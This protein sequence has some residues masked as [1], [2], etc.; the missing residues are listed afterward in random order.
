MI[1]KLAIIGC[2]VLLMSSCASRKAY[3]PDA[4][5]ANTNAY[6]SFIKVKRYSTYTNV[7]G[8][9]IA[10]DS[11][12]II[13]MDE[14][15]DQCVRIPIEDIFEFK[16]RY[17]NSRQYGW[18]IPFAGILPF[19]HGFYSLLTIPTHLIVTII[20]TSSGNR[21]YTYNSRVISY[22]ELVM[23]ARFPQGLPPNVDLSLIK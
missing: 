23:F 5:T 8:E 22:K 4:E 13:V 17:A 6:G 20:V 1:N 12:S 11:S 2:I 9:L 19:M 10:L 21:A 15:L 3:L 14:K 18:S 7:K 16:L